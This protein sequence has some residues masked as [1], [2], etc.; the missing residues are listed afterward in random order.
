MSLVVLYEDNHLI[1]VCKPAGMVTQHT[2]AGDG[3]LM[4]AVKDYLRE[5][6]HK[7]GEVFLGLLHRLDRSVTG[8]VMLAKTSKGASRLSEQ[9][10]ERALQKTYWA[11]VQ[12]TPEPAEATLTHYHALD[13]RGASVSAAPG[14]GRKPARLSYRVLRTF[15]AGPPA[16]SGPSAA[17]VSLVEVDLETGRKHQIRLQL[18]AIGHPIL[19]DRVYGARQPFAPGGIALVAKRVRFAHPVHRQQQMVVELPVELCPLSQA[20]AGMPA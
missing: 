6:Y 7:P 17:P 9:L 8:V 12:G 13:A 19:G 3:C 11:L 20:G 16:R 1:G 14:P 10:R 18:A 2:R 5:K 4:D 15:H